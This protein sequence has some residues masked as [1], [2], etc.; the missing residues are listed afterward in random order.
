RASAALERCDAALDLLPRL[1]GVFVLLPYLLRVR[2]WA[3]AA[4][5]RQE[6][7][8]EVLRSSLAGAR[9]KKADYEAAL[10]ADALAQVMRSLG[11]PSSELEEVRDSI[12]TELG[13]EAP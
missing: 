6:E 8:A 2:G 3:L 11:E 12:F 4:L 7:A 10:T 1:E 13:V 5:G 9:E